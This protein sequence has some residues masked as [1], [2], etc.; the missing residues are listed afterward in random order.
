MVV[1]WLFMI[2]QCSFDY[3]MSGYLFL[4]KLPV[5]VVGYL[6]WP[7]TPPLGCCRSRRWWVHLQDTANSAAVCY[8]NLINLCCFCWLDW[9]NHDLFEICVYTYIYMHS[10]YTV[11]LVTL[12]LSVSVSN[13]KIWA[14]P[15]PPLQH[16]TC[17]FFSVYEHILT[18]QTLE[19][20]CFEDF[21]HSSIW[22]HTFEL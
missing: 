20:N 18:T 22:F 6:L 11:S 3:V 2:L 12:S 1:F 10:V 21:R 17:S 4:G 8:W 9:N 15:V 13:S 16:K 5:K 7:S 19:D 14:S